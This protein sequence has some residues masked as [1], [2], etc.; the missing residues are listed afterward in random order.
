MQEDD[1]HKDQ[2]AAPTTSIPV[3]SDVKPAEAPVSE[4]P[5]TE[6]N[7][8]GAM[9][10]PPKDDVMPDLA[11]ESDSSSETI[12]AHVGSAAPSATDAIKKKNG[13]GMV[14]GIVVGVVIV[15][16]A[17]GYFAFAK[18]DKTTSSANTPA[19]SQSVTAAKADPAAA[20]TAIDSNLSPLDQSKDFNSAALSDTSLGL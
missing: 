14:I 16:A 3:M 17:V 13:M 8:N 10:T 11:S 18:K 15:L 19:T 20:S 6:S 4:S 9:A 7:G 5:V 12:P 2:T 1:S